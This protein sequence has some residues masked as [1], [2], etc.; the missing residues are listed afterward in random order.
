MG[1]NE[2]IE[3]AKDFAFQ[4]LIEESR[5]PDYTIKNRSWREDEVDE[6]PNKKFFALEGSPDKAFIIAELDTGK[7]HAFNEARELLKTFNPGDED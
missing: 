2:R 3:K 6:K 7:V 5:N 4:K 1:I